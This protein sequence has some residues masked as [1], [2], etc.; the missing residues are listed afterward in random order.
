MPGA[1]KNEDHT[2]AAHEAVQCQVTLQQQ[3]GGNTLTGF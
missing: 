2:S 1:Q 3:V